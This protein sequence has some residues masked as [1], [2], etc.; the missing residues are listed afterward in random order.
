MVAGPIGDYAAFGNV[1][2]VNGSAD[3]YGALQFSRAL[4]RSTVASGRDEGDET[5]K[6]RPPVRVSLDGAELPGR[7]QAAAT[8]RLVG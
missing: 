2:Q 3:L 7:G 4:G 6:T 8:L 1:E 5:R